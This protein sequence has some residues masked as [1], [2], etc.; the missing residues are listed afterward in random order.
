M[1]K[2]TEL[3]SREFLLEHFDFREDGRVFVKKRIS[4]RSKQVGDEVGTVRKTNQYLA[5][6]VGG[7]RFQLHRLIFFIFNGWCPVEIDHIDMNKYNNAPSNLRPAN[8]CGNLANT[9]K[10]AWRV[11]VPPSSKYKGVCWDKRAKKWLV[12][13][14]VS[15]K[16]IYLGLFADEQEARSVY[17]EAANRHFGEFARTV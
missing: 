1:P 4:S 6:D 16:Q 13:I 5:T 12:K 2:L 7:K 9:L 10:M 15:G 8:R 14:Q 3:P 11:G 17:R